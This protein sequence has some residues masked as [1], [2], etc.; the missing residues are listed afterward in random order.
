MG[1]HSDHVRRNAID[2]ALGRC[3]KSQGYFLDLFPLL[4]EFLTLQA[5]EPS[6]RVR[7]RRIARQQEKRK[8][9]LGGLAF[10]AGIAVGWLVIGWT[11]F[12]P[13]QSDPRDLSPAA[14][15]EYVALVVDSWSLNRD[16]ALA[17][18]R[19]KGLD[20]EEITAILSDLRAEYRQVGG[21]NQAARVSAFAAGYGLNLEN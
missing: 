13:L 2:T 5:N 18:E 3:Y 16:T 19:L 7:E 8:W 10:V 17:Q 20:P 6:P 21:T 4:P 15:L 9:L 14:K 12:P 1:P 11:I